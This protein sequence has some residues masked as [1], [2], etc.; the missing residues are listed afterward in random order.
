MDL[1]N[2]DSLLYSPIKYTLIELEMIAFFF[3]R[4]WSNGR[5]KSLLESW[6]MYYFCSRL[7]ATLNFCLIYFKII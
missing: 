4:I 3:G 5:G 7:I 6:G 2:P 1:L